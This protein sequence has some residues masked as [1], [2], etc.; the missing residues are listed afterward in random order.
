MNLA[1]F[2]VRNPVIA[3]L[4]MAAVLVAGAVAAFQLRKEM[5]PNVDPEAITVTVAYP[6]AT[7][8]EVERL[9]ARRLERSIE[10]IEDIDEVVTNVFEGLCAMRIDLEENSDRDRVLSDVRGAIDEVAPELPE[11]AEEP[12]ILAIRPIL[13]VISVVVHGDVAEARLRE[14]AKLVRD[15]LLD[16]DPVSEI[17]ISG[18]RDREIW[19]EIMP[20]RLEGWELTLEQVGRVLQQ[21]NLDLPAGQLKSERGNIRVRTLGE[22]DDVGEIEEIIV[23]TLPDGAVRLRD[24]ARV[25][26]TFEDTVEQGRFQGKPAANLT[27]FKTP[28]EDAVEIADA[29][30]RYVAENPSRFGAAVTLSTTRDLSR[31]IRQRLDLM[32][33][34]ARIGLVL[35][36]IVLGLFLELRVAFW[37]A[38]GLGVS[39]MGTFLLMLLAGVTINLITMFGL[40]VVLGL[41]VDDAIVIAENVFTKRREGLPGPRAAI[42]G[43]NEVAGPVVAAVL[44]TIA[45]FSPLAFLPGRIG[46][47]LGVLPVVVVAALSVSLI[48]AFIVL[49]AHISHVKVAGDG[50]FA[51]LSAKIDSARRQVLDIWLPN[52]FERVLRFLL[53]WR[54]PTLA[55]ALVFWMVAIG[56][57]GGGIVP[58]T[59]IGS[60][61]AETMVVDLEMAP[62]SSEEQTLAALQQVEALVLAEPEVATCFAMLGG[63]FADGRR[64]NVSDPATIGQITVELKAADDRAEQGLRRTSD[65]VNELRTSSKFITGVRRLTYAPLGGGPAGA[66]IEIRL[67][68][69]DLEDVRR[70]RDHVV[71]L[72]RSFRGVTE[73]YDDLVEGKLELRYQLRDD[74]RPLGLTTRDLALQTRYALFG[75]EVQDLQ[76]EDEE[77]TVRVLLPEADRREVADLARMRVAAPSGGRVPLAE[78]AHLKTERGYGALTRVDGKRAVT[79]FGAVDERVGNI[80]EITLALEDAVRELPGKFNGVTAAFVGSKRDAQESLAGL[81]VGFLTALLLIYCIVAILFRSYTQPLLVMAAIP[82]AFS[83]VVFGHAFLSYPITLL[84]MIGTVALAGIVVNDSLI[85]VELVNRKRREE[86][87]PLFEAVVLGSRAR[88]RAIL[89]T[90]V[91]TIA[92]LAPLMMETSF[93]AQFL[94]P[95]AIAIVF[96]LA[97][98]TGLIL[99]IVPV[100]YLMLEDVRAALRWAFQMREETR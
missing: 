19:V 83:G 37:V 41:L 65:V 78:V 74:A 35:V 72:V 32:V 77:V 31:F 67:R 3:N 5:F 97:F 99:V 14:A 4:L 1:R 42:K 62:G 92:G 18:I 10:G 98:A 58:F 71:A 21:S 43:T 54:Y 44:T 56:M 26:E 86:R 53:R 34:N 75:F 39:F 70:A 22:T 48:E 15:D 55:V 13:P 87:I 57:L 38:V 36:V 69:T 2:A 73:A 80:R 64:K 52:G 93:Q 17:T 27:V 8:E 50:W 82:L 84:S 96:G 89:L 85:L 25:R 61:D 33:R 90:S 60:M 40:I 6:G 9:V 23:K 63:A 49:P 12:E 81:R 20:E 16:L 29:V 95:M 45:A 94:V 51:R 76:D 47:F 100:L 91:T 46:A 59:L 88:L 30:K 11:D 24:I 68:G 28:E 66:D 7:P 79:V